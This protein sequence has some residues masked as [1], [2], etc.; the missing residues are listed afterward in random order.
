MADKDKERSPK[1]SD[2]TKSQTLVRGL[3]L[4]ESV[5]ERPLTISGMSAATGISYSTVHRITS[6]LVSCGYLRQS[7]G[8]HFSLGPKIMAL[9]F[10]AHQ[11]IDIVRVA[12]P[13][14]QELAEKT[15]D[16]VHLARIEDNAVIYLDKIRSTRPIEVSSRIGGRKP[17]IT[18]G[19]GKA[20]LLNKG[21]KELNYY[22]DITCEILDHP[23]DKAYWMKRMKEY[24]RQGYAFDFGED[25][26]S[27]R[28]VAVPIYDGSRDIVAAVSVSSTQE[29]MPDS[30]IPNLVDMVRETARRVSENMGGA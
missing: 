20:L 14:L 6:V 30:R 15:S 16:T 18:T 4:M 19:V 28:C 12:H 2:M 9:G 1:K 26:P 27:I 10:S 7:D 3:N 17:L 21:E 23:V 24:A 8:K 25:E 5:A 22:F 13:Y 29:Y 11:Q